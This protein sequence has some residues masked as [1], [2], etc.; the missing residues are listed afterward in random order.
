M[1]GIGFSGLLA[2]LFIAFKLAG[3]INWSWVWVLSP[4][5]LGIAIVLAVLGLSVGF[6]GLVEFI[7]NIKRARR[8]RRHKKVKGGIK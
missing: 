5:W 2:I 3:I 1:K 7:S 4:L 6:I 8:R